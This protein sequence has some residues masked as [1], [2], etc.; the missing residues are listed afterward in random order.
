MTPIGKLRQASSLR[1]QVEQEIASAI[2]SGEIAPG[3]LVSAPTLAARFEVS[4]TPVREAMLNLEKR[5]F[6]SAVRNKG[7]RVTAVDQDALTRLAEVRHLLEPEAMALLAPRF[8][9]EMAGRARA[10]ADEIVAGAA[11]ED[12]ATYLTADRT[13]HLLLLEFLGNSYLVD[14]V[15]DL[16]E[17]TRLVGLTDLLQTRRLAASAAEH[18]QLVDLLEQHDA[19]G[20]RS[21]MHQ[22]IGHVTGWW[23]GT[24]ER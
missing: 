16:R 21:L 23:S 13:F 2:V 15:A 10:L 18:H 19:D 24:E 1:Q 22:H 3:E 5:G 20:A 7:F 11:G 9:D 6:V 8:T 4:A 14:I 12:L 17:R